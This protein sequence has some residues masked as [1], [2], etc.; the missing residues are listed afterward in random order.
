MSILHDQYGIHTE[1][2]RYR[3][4]LKAKIQEAFPGKL[5]FLTVDANTAEVLIRAD[6]INSHTLVNEREHLLRQA[7]EC[8]RKDILDHAQSLPNLAWPARIEELLSD[9]RKQPETLEY[10]F[11]SPS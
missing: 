8:L 3:S 10:F 11:E 1:D 4:K 5:H 7:S 6:A 9:A 2:T